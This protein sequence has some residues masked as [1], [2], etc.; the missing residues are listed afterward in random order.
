MSY[1]HKKENNWLNVVAVRE[2]IQSVSLL[3][4][5][6]SRST[7]Y[8]EKGL[9]AEYPV[10]KELKFVS[11]LEERT[12][13]CI[14]TPYFSVRVQK[15]SKSYPHFTFLFMCEKTQSHIHTLL[16]SSCVRKNSKLNLHTLFFNN[17]TSWYLQK[18]LKVASSV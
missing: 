1:L 5:G 15:D 3:L 9:K 13:S 10:K 4:K 11:L 17:F 2:R 12:Q 6:Y 16:F 7:L 8:L 18:G 14:S